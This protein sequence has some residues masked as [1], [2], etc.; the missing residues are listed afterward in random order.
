MNT[1]LIDLIIVIRVNNIIKL[2]NHDLIQQS[3]SSA[4]EYRVR[5]EWKFRPHGICMT[6]KNSFTIT[7]F[8]LLL[9][10]HPVWAA[11]IGD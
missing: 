10:I 7:C 1:S 5:T 4:G 6:G 9:F 8:A 3:Y 11:P 2:M